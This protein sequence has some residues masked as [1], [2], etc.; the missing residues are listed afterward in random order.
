VSKEPPLSVRLYFQEPL[1]GLARII[2]YHGLPVPRLKEEARTLLEKY[3]KERMERAAGEVV[4][5][6]TST[7]P[8]TA[9]LQAGV[10]KLCRQLL[11]APPEPRGNERAAEG[12]ARGAQEG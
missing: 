5:V 12:I 10:R 3:G 1:Y 7:D 9:R 8:P 2:G 6:D 11:G 4:W